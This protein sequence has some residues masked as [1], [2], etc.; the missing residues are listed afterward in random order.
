MRRHYRRNARPNEN[1]IATVRIVR[2]RNPKKK[3]RV[4]RR[5]SVSDAASRLAYFRHH[6]NPGVLTAAQVSGLRKLLRLESNPRKRGKRRGKKRSMARRKHRRVRKARHTRVRKSRRVR[7]S[8]LPKAPKGKRAGSIFKRKGKYFRV[9][10][11][12]VRKGR[13]VIRRR[14]VRKTTARAARMARK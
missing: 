1:D 3:R 14:V 9:S 7:R 12:K 13:R 2:R 6:H 10:L 5:I 4:G 8:K 11:V